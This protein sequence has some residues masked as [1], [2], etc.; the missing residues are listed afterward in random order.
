MIS[1]QQSS[2]R[3]VAP[4]SVVA[5]VHSFVLV[6]VLDLG[7]ILEVRMRTHFEGQHVGGLQSHA[8]SIIFLEIMPPVAVLIVEIMSLSRCIIIVD[9]CIG[10]IERPLLKAVAEVEGLL[11]TL[12]TVAFHAAPQLHDGLAYS[13]GD[14]EGRGCGVSAYHHCHDSCL[15][16]ATAKGATSGGCSSPR[17]FLNGIVSRWRRTGA[18]SRW[19]GG[20]IVFYNRSLRLL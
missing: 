10:T 13:T 9:T 20:A 3:L 2:D 1:Q 14:A 15:Q 7:C 11:H 8:D 4:S 18:T 16:E 12:G 17:G 5:L 19:L 6:W